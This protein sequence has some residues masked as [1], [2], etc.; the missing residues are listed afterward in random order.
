MTKSIFGKGRAAGILL[1]LGLVIGLLG[2]TNNGPFI[3][4]AKD[5][6][7]EIARSSAKAYLSLR[8]INAAISFAEE[9]EVGGSVI[10]VS[11]SAHPFKV[12]EPIDDAVERL[13][14][15]IF[16]V[17]AVSGVLAVVLPL[18][19]S[20]ALVLIGAS[21]AVQAGLE[22]S[23]LRFPG[24]NFLSNLFRGT[25]R[26]GGLGFLIVIAFSIS[27]WFADGV[28]NRAW[29]EYQRTLTNIA[30]KMPS[31]AP[32]NVSMFDVEQENGLEDHADL[33]RPEVID[34][35]EE[36]TGLFR[37]IGNGLK[38][39]SEGAANI[40]SSAA[41]GVADLT[42]GAVDSVKGA[43]SS[44]TASYNKAKNILTVLTAQSDDLVLALM[45]VFAAFL[46]KTVVCPML[47]LIG[48]WKLAGSFEF[49]RRDEQTPTSETSAQ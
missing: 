44:A 48:L 30:E 33:V 5:Y 43:A 25:A 41:S 13:S 29:G 35:E 26:L 28:S 12:L 34:L 32:E 16:L 46:F 45:G 17:G 21:L 22:L 14:A 40:A 42:T 1:A 47:T 36:E 10:A 15:A 2:F 6:S 37:K 9:V 38:A 23:S 24:Q 18:L 20:V 31:L 4:G 39:T 27:S 19:G 7:Q 8:L 3:K 11:G 49:M